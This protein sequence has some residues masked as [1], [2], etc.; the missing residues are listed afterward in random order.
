MARISLTKEELPAIALDVL[1]LHHLYQAR[2]TAIGAA[3][4]ERIADNLAQ[5]AAAASPEGN[6]KYARER[7]E[8]RLGV[9]RG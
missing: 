1:S 6:N 2:G 4:V 5:N 7:L 3:D 8:A 9:T